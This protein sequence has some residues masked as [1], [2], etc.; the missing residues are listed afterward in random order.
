MNYN[1]KSSLFIIIVVVLLVMHSLV[2][3]TNLAGK[4]S[5]K[6]PT[7]THQKMV[8]ILADLGK[9]I[10][11]PDN[12]YDS[13]AR[14]RLCDSLLGT[15]HDVGPSLDILF[16][17]ANALL[18]YG[19]EKQ[20]VTIYEHLG[21]F[22][23]EN[24]NSRNVLL[25]EMGMAYL[26]LGERNNCVSGHASES[27]IMPIRGNGI[28]QSKTGSQKA[29]AIYE[30]LLAA[31]PDDL[32]SRWLLNIA[33]MTLGE[34][35]GK[36]P[37]K[38]LIPDLDKTGKF[39]VKPFEDIAPGLKLNVN[40]RAG[41]VIA[42]DF[43][44][45]GY[46]DL[47][48]SAWGLDDPMYFMLN[49][50]DGTF[51][52][53]S[54]ASGINTIMGGLNITSTDYNN[55]GWTDI[56]VLRGGWQ[57]QGGFGNQP[58][59]LLRNN[60]DGTFTDVTIDAGLLSFHPTQTATWNDFNNDGWLDVFIGNEAMSATDIHPCELYLNNR[61]GTFTNIATPQL[62]D[63]AA[64]VK[65]VTS[66]DYN[67]DGWADIFISTQ[68]G[69][70][71]LL[72]NLKALGQTAVFG[73]VS[74]KAGLKQS[75]RTF[76]TGFFDYDN[77]GW[78]DIFICNYDFQRPLSYY[79]A[80]E[81]L[82]PSEDVTG[83]LCFYRNNRNGTF[84]DVTKSVGVNQ[85]VFAMGNNFGDID[86]DGF[87]DLYFGTGNPNYRSLVPNKMFKNLGGKKFVDVTASA[88]VGNLQKGHGISFA[89]LD[90]DG[91]QD[92]YA[93]MGGAFHGDGYPSA[94]YLNPGQSDNNWICLKL[95]GVK[96][97]RAAIGAKV[98]VKFQENGQQRIVYREVNS[99][100]SFGC[101]PLRREIG[102]GQ[103]TVIDEIIVT[104]P[105]TGIIQSV[106][107]VQPNQ[108][109]KIKEGQEG[110]EKVELKKLV[111]RKADGTIPMCAPVQ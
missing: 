42:D 81:A 82:S 43:N 49:N 40:N 31:N 41:G 46:L 92:L 25:A 17:K 59:S 26:R 44:N 20:A 62:L 47:V 8:K 95:E 97:N 39:R 37:A 35:P 102:I 79:A 36:V 98:T 60:G 75:T 33:Y 11:Q 50:G 16:R 69:Q 34:Y 67:N 83:K 54:Q 48:T 52:D 51:S 12:P 15:M 22:T 4:Q 105:A 88:R 58:N 103:A 111:F 108:F 91:D 80:K 70:L 85:I 21:T 56:F 29:I 32:D 77:D 10:S 7:D 64:F 14:V 19:D 61:N 5:I 30:T 90:N 24:A 109:I 3:C 89:D 23:Y 78:L 66:G 84:S 93:E 74:E 28:H 107:N 104:W 2:S 55:D 13:G 65:G 1:Q 76:G 6:E 110:L 96:S 73:I 63:I 94:L 87:L 72:E 106:K 9:K 18:E 27:C 53:R 99:G 38:W 57:A 45:D 101:S 68:N 100:A 86:N 71:L